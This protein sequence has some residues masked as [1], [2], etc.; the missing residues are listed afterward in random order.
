VEIRLGQCK[1]CPATFL[2]CRPCDRVRWYCARCKPE[3]TCERLERAR[4]KYRESPEGKEQHASEERDRRERCRGAVGD[5][6]RD[7]ENVPA[8]VRCQEV[9]PVLEQRTEEIAEAA[10]REV[11][12]VFTR[13]LRRSAEALVG[14][15]VAC[16]ECGRIGLVTRLRASARRW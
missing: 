13:R 14:C 4:R 12:L 9:A 7:K 16:G 6:G 3:A 10:P 1:R 2:V 5:R 8:T 11:A 15:L